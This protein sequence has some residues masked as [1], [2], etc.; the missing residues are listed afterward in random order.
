M[1]TC[2]SLSGT[3]RGGVR[4]KTAFYPA[5][6]KVCKRR[7]DKVLLGFLINMSVWFK[8][9]W[10]NSTARYADHISLIPKLVQAS[11]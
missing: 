6:R 2:V 10:T 8:L 3:L 1:K 5:L 11:A 9:S 7:Q 4:V